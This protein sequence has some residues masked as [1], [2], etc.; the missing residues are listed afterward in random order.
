M[1]ITLLSLSSCQNA[2]DAYGISESVVAIDAYATSIDS[3]VDDSIEMGDTSSLPIIKD[4][5]EAIRSE[6]NKAREREKDL[7]EEIA[8]LKDTSFFRKTVP[9]I[10]VA[11]GVMCLGLGYMTKD[12][13]DTVAGVVLFICGVVLN[14]YWSFIGLSGLII[15]L[16]FG[17]GW[18]I[19]S[20]DWK[21]AKRQLL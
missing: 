6:G 8:D 14:R 4:H 19:V 2:K 17:I 20:F 5:T 1:I 15:M 18:L 13:E 21:K 12:I 10:P 11:L 16:I 3:I 9:W 7:L